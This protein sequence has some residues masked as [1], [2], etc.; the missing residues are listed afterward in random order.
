MS[1][2]GL[3][4]TL[5]PAHSHQVL[6]TG[7]SIEPFQ[8]G[9]LLTMQQGTQLL[10]SAGIWRS[11]TELGLGISKLKVANVAMLHSPGRTSAHTNHLS[12]ISHFRPKSTCVSHKPAIIS[13]SL[14]KL[15]AG[16]T[17]NTELRLYRTLL[18]RRVDEIPTAGNICCY[19]GVAIEMSLILSALVTSGQGKGRD[20][21]ESKA[22]WWEAPC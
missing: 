22:G 2:L 9:S 7:H 20:Y 13:I 10:S 11:H 12:N 3:L 8:F 14:C 15:Q 1:L 18:P 19:F 17:T 5:L 4:P 16:E 6:A 21:A